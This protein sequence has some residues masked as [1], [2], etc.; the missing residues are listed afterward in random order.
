MYCFCPTT[1]L[2]Q[3]SPPLCWLA[4]FQCLE[5]SSSLERSVSSCA[6]STTTVLFFT[7]PA[8]HINWGHICWLLF[9]RKCIG[10]ELLRLTN[11]TLKHIHSQ[12]YGLFSLCHYSTMPLPPSFSF[13]LLHSPCLFTSTQYRG[14]ELDNVRAQLR[15][16]HDHISLLL[17]PWKVS[18]FGYAWKQNLERCY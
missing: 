18:N 14:T 17:L 10:L 4:T 2:L 7:G 9:F 16:E 5:P 3:N 1:P 8:I 12:P 6:E 15:T 13:A 11:S